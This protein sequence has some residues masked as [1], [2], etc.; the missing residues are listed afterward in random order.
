MKKSVT[1]KFYTE[2]VKFDT[3]KITDGKY[4][5]VSIHEEQGLNCRIRKWRI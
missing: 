5:K 4:R 1:P 3:K 2:F